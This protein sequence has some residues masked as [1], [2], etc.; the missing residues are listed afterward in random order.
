MSG[1]YT[2]ADYLFDRIAELGVRHIFGV[3]GDFNL[4]F[5]D[6]VLAHDQLEWV[7]NNNELNGGYAAD[8]YARLKGF[9]AMVTT[10]GVGELSAINA[11]GGS[12][13]EYAPVLHI[14]GA[15]STATRKKGGKVHHTLGDGDFTHFFD[16]A[17]H[18]SCAQA[19]LDDT[20]APADIDRV[21]RTMLA[22]HRPGYIVLPQDIADVPV[23]RPDE[24]IN[25]DEVRRHTTSSGALKAFAE[26]AAEF[27]DGRQA[28]V[29]TDM[30]VLRVGARDQLI[31]L[32]DHCD[33]PYCTLTWGKSIVY[34]NS[35]RF[36]GIYTGV[37]SP[38][39][40]KDAVENAERLIAAGVEFTDSTSAGFSMRINPENMLRID[41]GKVTVG[42]RGFAPIAMADALDTLTTIITTDATVSPHPLK[43]ETVSPTTEVDPD[44]PLTQNELWTI[45]ADWMPGDTLC[46]ADQGTS[47][48]GMAQKPVPDT[49]LFM[50]QPLWGSIGYTIPAALGAAIGD[51]RNRRP[52]VLIGDGSAQLT[53]QEIAT[54]LRQ[55][56]CPV[57]VLVNNDG[58]TI[59]RTIH[60]PDQ[61]YNDIAPYNWQYIPKA[62][63]AT[64]D[65]ALV[66]DARTPNQL[67]EALAQAE[68]ATDKLVFVEVHTDADDTPDFLATV[69]DAIKASGSQPAGE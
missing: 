8:G 37:A 4:G 15:P 25:Q 46:L 54:H 64:D 22:E 62:F 38:P 59:E 48:F 17:R 1:T 29:L 20:S 5:L 50:G 36:A 43:K 65:T 41:P 42:G 63:G 45:I 9:G 7:G 51:D 35:E 21:I 32:L 12:Y 14:V 58:Y 55:K 18:V 26:A 24:P 16:M 66:L 69:F 19:W 23:Y 60:G 56:T 49:T 2:V 10:F 40:T 52:I 68:Q 31:N 13:A 30:L 28:T 53:V 3:P 47:F 57:I 27:L 61:A 67:R 44:T 33:L 39:A 34:E 6:T 11:S